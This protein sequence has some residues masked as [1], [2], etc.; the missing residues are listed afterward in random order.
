MRTNKSRLVESVN[1]LAEKRYLDNKFNP[2]EK[3]EKPKFN[4]MPV[5]SVGPVNFVVKEVKDYTVIL[6][7][8]HPLAG[9]KLIFDLELVGLE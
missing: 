5:D 6:D 2:K 1:L 9:K 3:K 7:A 8:N 4:V